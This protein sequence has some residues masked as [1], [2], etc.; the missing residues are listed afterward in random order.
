[1]WFRISHFFTMFAMEQ[2]R[3]K[4]CKKDIYTS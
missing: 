3:K 4:I 1:M 2:E